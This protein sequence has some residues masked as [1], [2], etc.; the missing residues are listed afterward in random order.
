[1]KSPGVAASSNDDLLKIGERISRYCAYQERSSLEAARKLREWKVPAVKVKEILDH[2]SEGGF[3]DDARFAHIFAKSKFRHNKWG[4]VKI[5]Y[6]LLSRGIPENIIPDALKEIDEAEYLETIRELIIKKQKEIKEGKNLNIR[7][8]IIT[9]VNGKG[10][11]SDLVAA[12]LN[13]LKI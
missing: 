7:E 4:R 10:F 13:E 6:E 9:F 11:E 12:T 8:K 5:R 3:I 2:L 1:M